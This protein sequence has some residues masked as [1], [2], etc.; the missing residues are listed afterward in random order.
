M[1]IINFVKKN[2]K[3]ST[4]G[5][6]PDKEDQYLEACKLFRNQRIKSRITRKSLSQ[7]T[8]ISV[9]VIEAIEKG[10]IDKLPEKTYLKRM[11]NILENELSLQTKALDSI[12]I[13]S[14]DPKKIQKSKF[15]APGNLNI[16][17]SWQGSIIYITFMFFCIITLNRYQEYLIKINSLNSQPLKESNII[18]NPNNTGEAKSTS[19]KESN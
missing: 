4:S 15:F 3:S 14:N 6:N 18:L 1:F 7:R 5:V 8:K 12:L 13:K 17:S 11:L 19:I 16:F 10:W 2:S 9:R